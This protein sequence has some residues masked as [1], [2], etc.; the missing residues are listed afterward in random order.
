MS[1]PYQETQIKGIKMNEQEIKALAESMG[2]SV[3][4]FMCLAQSVAN[5][6]QQDKASAAFMALPA[7]DRED[8]AASYVVHAVKKIDQFTS[9]YLT[10][11]EARRAF[12]SNVL[13][14]I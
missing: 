7:D 2:V 11:A 6:I 10:N 13:A 5:S 3:A 4:D 1:S 12:Q 14:I 8:M 9:T